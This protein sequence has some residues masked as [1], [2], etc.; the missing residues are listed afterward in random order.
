MAGKVHLI[1][2]NGENYELISAAWYG[3]GT[4]IHCF[5]E[6]KQKYYTQYK[7]GNQCQLCIPLN[8]DATGTQCGINPR[9]GGYKAL[10]KPVTRDL[11]KPPWL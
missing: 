3:T 6:Y 8:I 5:D 10:Q 9:A 11:M 1:N 7:I 2:K 4:L